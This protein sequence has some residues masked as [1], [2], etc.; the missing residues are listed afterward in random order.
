MCL[1]EYENINM[2]KLTDMFKAQSDRITYIKTTLNSIETQIR[3]FSLENNMY[4]HTY[5]I[6]SHFFVCI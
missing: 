6:H 5:D 2:N 3:R 4:P 1:N